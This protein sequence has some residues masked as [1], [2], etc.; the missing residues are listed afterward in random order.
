MN[1]VYISGNVGKDPEQRTTQNGVKVAT[2]TLACYRANPKD[3][4]K[5]LTD[6]YNIVAWGDTADQVMNNVKKGSKILVTGRFQTRNY[7]D[8]D[9]KTVYTT[10]LM[11]SELW[12]APN[13][14]KKAE[15]TG[16]VF[17]DD[18]LPF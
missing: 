10:E 18:S 5:P 17:S 11:Q 4:D 15:D 6:W 13:K 9:N 3:K 2:Y 8:K 12:L 16:S 1:N 14:E 7:Q